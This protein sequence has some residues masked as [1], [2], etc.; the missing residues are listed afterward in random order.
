[1]G[2]PKYI[3]NLVIDQSSDAITNFCGHIREIFAC[4]RSDI[5]LLCQELDRQHLEEIRNCLFEKICE[6]QPSING[7]IMVKRRKKEKAY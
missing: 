3:E 2:I 5:E 7:H 4:T 6:Q 1:M